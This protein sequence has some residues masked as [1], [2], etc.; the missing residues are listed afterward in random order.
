MKNIT[1]A[2][3]DDTYRKARI[4]AARRDSSVSGLVKHYLITLSTEEEVSRDLKREQEVMLDGLW[5]KYP[6]FSSREN[7]RR[8]ELYERRPA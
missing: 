4:A 3:D 1:I 2:L 8:D 5:E 7:L 6:T